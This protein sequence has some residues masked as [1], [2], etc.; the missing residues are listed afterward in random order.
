MRPVGLANRLIKN[1]NDTSLLVPEKTDIEMS[2]E[3]SNI[4]KWSAD[5]KLT[6]NL[7]KMKEIAFHKSNPRNYLPS[8]E[9]NGIERVD[10]AKLLGVWLQND[11]G[12]GKQVEYITRICNQRLY[13]A[14]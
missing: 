1:A 10:I 2:Q 9:L 3:F 11:M 13:F 6:V 4:I 8:A 7:A 5:N 12:A 14:K